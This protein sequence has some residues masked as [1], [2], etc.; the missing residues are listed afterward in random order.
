MSTESHVNVFL[1]IKQRYIIITYGRYCGKP[2]FDFFY[3][4]Q[5]LLAEITVLLSL[6]DYPT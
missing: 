3:S 4:N 2:P 1:K 5:T 6:T